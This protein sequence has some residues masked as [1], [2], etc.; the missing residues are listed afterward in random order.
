MR[1]SITSLGLLAGTLLFAP[2][3]ARADGPGDFSYAWND[4]RYETGVGISATLGGGIAG[5]TDQAMRDTMSASAGGAWDLH[6]TLGSHTPLAVELGY[7]G[8]AGT[9]N[10]LSGAK[11]GTLVGTTAE[12]A[13]R[14]N[15]LPH[16]AWNPYAFAG[17]GWQR[18]DI[19]GD[20]TFTLS[21]TGMNSSDD[22]VVFP[23]GLGVGYRGVSGLVL[24]LRGTFRA[25]TNQGLVLKDIGSNE[26]VPMHTWEASA[27]VGL[28]F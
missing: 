27:A 21:D 14:Y 6:V 8:T 20:D 4:A 22:S 2:M 3:A 1:T 10:A 16:H 13:L 24:D 5:F 12:G 26:Y 7:V 9:I 18:Y 23:M 11:S 15:A 17:I 25:N 19:T 28:E